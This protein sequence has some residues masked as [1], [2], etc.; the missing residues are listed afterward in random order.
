MERSNTFY[1]EWE[2][3][4]ASKKDKA[5]EG[6]AGLARLLVELRAA[7]SVMDKRCMR[8]ETRPSIE[9]KE[10]MRRK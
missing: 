3:R 7:E 4:M 6:L 8:G 1:A 2:K 5:P 10:S 9:M